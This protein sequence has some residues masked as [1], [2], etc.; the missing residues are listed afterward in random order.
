M[1]AIGVNDDGYREVIGA[2]EG[3]TESSEFWREFLSW[4]RFRGLRGVRMITGDKTA[5]M[6]GSIAEVFPEVAYQR[7][8]AHFYRSALAKVP[9]KKRAE[10]AAM[11]EAIHAMESREAAEAKALEAVSKLDTMKLGGGREG[12]PRRLPGDPGLHGV[13]ARTLAAR[14]HQQRHRADQPRDTQ[15][16]PRRGDVPRR[17]H[18]PYA[19]HRPAQVRRGERVGLSPLLGRDAAGRVAMPEDGPRGC[20]KVRKNLDG[21][22]RMARTGRNAKEI[23]VPKIAVTGLGD[24]TRNVGC[25][26]GSITYEFETKTFNYDRGIKLPADVMDVE[27]AGVLASN[28]PLHPLVRIAMPGMNACCLSDPYP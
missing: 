14:T 24:Y 20:R 25:K 19:R 15:A 2:A 27:E 22:R 5:G 17:K 3:F 13:P 11:P 7:C 18:R 21:T 12:R 1:V 23:M 9:K 26:T 6:A 16:H 8:T 4:L 10:V 28:W